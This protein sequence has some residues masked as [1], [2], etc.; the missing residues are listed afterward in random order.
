MMTSFQEN[1]VFFAF[2]GSSLLVRGDIETVALA[3]R[4]ASSGEAKERLALYV[5]GSGAAFDLDLSGS[6]EE[7]LARLPGQF[8]EASIDTL[9]DGC[10]APATKP[11]GR[12]RPKLGVV[13]REISLL[14]RHWQWL[15]EQQGGASATLRRLVDEARKIRADEAQIRKNVNAAYRFMM[16]IA[17][18]QAG[19]EEASRTLFAHNFREFEE[20]IRDWPTDIRTQLARYVEGAQLRQSGASDA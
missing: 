9:A 1:P 20:R 6:E 3:A 17:G 18:N 8:P 4:A 11:R 5:E 2:S 12:G 19:F 14:P 16:D 13:S 7:I 15:S 10:S